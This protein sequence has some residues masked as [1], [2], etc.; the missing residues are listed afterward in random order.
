MYLLV[1]APARKLHIFFGF[2]Y[3]TI[4]F[5]YSFSKGQM[6]SRQR[7]DISNPGFDAFRQNDSC[8]LI[9]VICTAQIG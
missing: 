7:I 6:Q 1:K 8:L 3:D 4:A 5:W 2:L 9:I